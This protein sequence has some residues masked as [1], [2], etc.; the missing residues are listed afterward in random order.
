MNCILM[1]HMRASN[2]L[3]QW[4]AHL[5]H[6]GIAIGSRQLLMFFLLVGG[7]AVMKSFPI[8]CQMGL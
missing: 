7:D 2:C 8:V 6:F 4:Q 5:E 1:K 3:S